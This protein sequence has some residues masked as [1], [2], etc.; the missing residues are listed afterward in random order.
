MVRDDQLSC[1]GEL[2][3]QVVLGG[4]SDAALDVEA[5]APLGIMDGRLLVRKRMHKENRKG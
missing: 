2:V 1:S 5:V 3:K 4:H